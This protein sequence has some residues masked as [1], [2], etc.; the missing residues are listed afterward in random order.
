MTI[1]GGANIEVDE[2]CLVEELG[3]ANEVSAVDCANAVGAEA[4]DRA[5]AGER[6][7]TGNILRGEAFEDGGDDYLKRGGVGRGDIV[8]RQRSFT[9][10]GNSPSRAASIISRAPSGRSMP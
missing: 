1:E 9:G 2:P 10:S 7:F 8:G 6:L 3:G 5:A 4:D